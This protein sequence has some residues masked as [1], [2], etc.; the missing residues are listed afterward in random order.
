MNLKSNTLAVVQVEAAVLFPLMIMIFAAL[1]LLAMYLP[2]RAALQY[3]TQY[4]A[5]AIATEL[6]DTWLSFNE[7]EM[8]YEREESIRNLQNVYTAFFGS[9][10]NIQAR[11]E[12]IVNNLNNRSLLL[13]D[14]ET[15]TNAVFV[16]AIVYREVIVIATHE[17]NVPIN[18]SIIGF[19]QQIGF[20]VTSVAAVNDGDEFIRILQLAGSFIE[21]VS[22][23]YGLT[24]TNINIVSFFERTASIL[25]R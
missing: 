17:F 10:T 2:M 7:Q 23:R 4:T 11:A 6:S 21:Y 14:G 9:P 24:D 16:N 22:D 25:T 19:P 20:T 5:T 12:Q 3:A 13:R 18:L 15:Q 8:K 1:T